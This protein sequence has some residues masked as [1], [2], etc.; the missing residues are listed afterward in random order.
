[1]PCY[2]QHSKCSRYKQISR[3]GEQW[4]RLDNINHF[5]GWGSV[6]CC[7]CCRYHYLINTSTPSIYCPGRRRCSRCRIFVVGICYLFVYY[8][9]LN[10]HPSASS[11]Q[12]PPPK[13]EQHQN[14]W[15]DRRWRT[16]FAKK[17]PWVNIRSV[18]I[19]LVLVACP[20]CQVEERTGSGGWSVGWINK[21]FK[22]NSH[23]IMS[24]STIAIMIESSDA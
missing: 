20:H 1:M 9:F 6:C 7:C 17:R 16:A 15:A 3:K 4:Q 12:P 19:S 22:R 24:C 11:L 10:C 13:T 18:L 5:G 23:M 21:I 8:T 2:S 14:N